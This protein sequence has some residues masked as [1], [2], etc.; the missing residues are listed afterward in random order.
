MTAPFSE[1]FDDGRHSS[2]EARCTSRSR[3]RGELPVDRRPAATAATHP[4][5]SEQ[6]E[7]CEAAPA[8][9]CR[10]GSGHQEGQHRQQSDA[11]GA[12]RARRS[13]HGFRL[14]DLERNHELVG[15]VSLPCRKPGEPSDKVS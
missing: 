14:Q 4:A 8:C 7:P 5:A 15:A 2:A 6:Q 10:A 12:D 9:S 11:R 3:E 13:L 1:L